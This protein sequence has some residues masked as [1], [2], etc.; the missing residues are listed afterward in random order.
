MPLEA[1]QLYLSNDV[2]GLSERSALLLRSVLA[3]AKGKKGEFG[4]VGASAASQ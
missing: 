1:L 3:F 4:A 2:A